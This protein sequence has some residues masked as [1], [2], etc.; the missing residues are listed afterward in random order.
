MSKKD[1]FY[2]EKMFILLNIGERRKPKTLFHNSFCQIFMFLHLNYH[3]IKN[4]KI[5]D[6][7]WKKIAILC[8]H[9]NLMD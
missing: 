7:L 4:A 2:I 8:F 3:K 1:H 5:W 9:H 6:F